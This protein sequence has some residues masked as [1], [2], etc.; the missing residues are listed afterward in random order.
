MATTIYCDR[1]QHN[2][3]TTERNYLVGD[4]LVPADFRSISGDG[5]PVWSGAGPLSCPGRSWIDE[6]QSMEICG[7]TTFSA[8]GDLIPYGTGLRT[9]GNIWYVG[10]AVK[11][12]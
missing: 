9:Q 11:V 7:G 5:T 3:W 1:R 4:R 8:Y 12:E 10:G 2:L 6:T